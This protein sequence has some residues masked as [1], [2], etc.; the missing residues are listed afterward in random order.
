MKKIFA[1]IML[2]FSCHVANPPQLKAQYFPAGGVL[3]GPL[4][5]Q[6]T[7]M[8]SVEFLWQYLLNTEKPFHK[9]IRDVQE[10]FGK[11]KIV[12]KGAVRELRMAKEIVAMKAEIIELLVRT[13]NK[14]GE[15]RDT[16]GDGEEDFNLLDKWRYIQILT[17]ISS[18]A[19][20][21]FELFS[22]VVEQDA[23]VMGDKARITYIHKVYREM[24]S[25][26]RAMYMQIRRINQ[27]MYGVMRGKREMALYKKLFRPTE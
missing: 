24:R 11:A 22:N 3:D 18:E 1:I 14:I 27:D 23:T 10:F 19:L 15:F 5:A 4:A 6:S 26:R 7:I 12:V 25:I 21:I 2:I 9:T 8:V 13:I 17:G 20:S 16:D